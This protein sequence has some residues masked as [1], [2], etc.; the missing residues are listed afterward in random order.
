MAWPDVGCRALALLY[1]RIEL[2]DRNAQLCTR[3]ENLGA[4][5]N[6]SKVLIIGD[7]DQ[8]V[9]HRVVEHPPPVSILLISRIDRRVVGF[10]PFAG[11]W[12][13]RRGEIGP[14]HTTGTLEQQGY[15]DD[16]PSDS[17]RANRHAS[18]S[19]IYNRRGGVNVIP[20]PLGTDPIHI[21]RQG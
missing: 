16:V 20:L 18:A 5:A 21:R 1:L 7:L 8:P 4:G 3:L 6:Q 15:S 12:G 19:S 11:D 17:M 14:N 9:E 13:R 10:E 2:T